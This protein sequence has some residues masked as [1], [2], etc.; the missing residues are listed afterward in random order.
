[1]SVFSKK[2]PNAEEALSLLSLPGPPCKKTIEQAADMFIQLGVGDH[3]T[4]YVIIRSGPLGAYVVQK[5]S[6]GV[7]IDAFFSESTSES[8]VDVTGRM[9]YLNI[10]LSLTCYHKEQETAS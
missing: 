9:T 10:S 6:D 3:E 7:W 4:G 5:R 1:M 2:S 8:I